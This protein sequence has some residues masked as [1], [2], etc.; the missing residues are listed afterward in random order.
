METKKKMRPYYCCGNTLCDQKPTKTCAGC[1]TMRYCSKECQVSHWKFHKDFCRNYVGSKMRSSESKKLTFRY[2]QF[3]KKKQN[4]ICYKHLQHTMESRG[5]YH[6]AIRFLLDDTQKKVE[7]ILYLKMDD[8]VP[9]D[10]MHS[11]L[12]VDMPEEYYDFAQKYHEETFSRTDNDP[13][14]VYC[15]D[16]ICLF[17]SSDK[18]SEV[19]ELEIRSAGFFIFGHTFLTFLKNPKIYGAG[20]YDDGLPFY[21]FTLMHHI[22]NTWKRSQRGKQII[23]KYKAKLSMYVKKRYNL[24]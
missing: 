2:F 3:F 1:G 15:V 8:F 7:N 18:I 11:S 16:K 19:M 22:P 4:E 5:K 20:S 24:K 12:R 6:V 14:D 17:F 9:K 13:S 21:A 10:V 23:K